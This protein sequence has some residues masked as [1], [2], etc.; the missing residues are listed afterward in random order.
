[1]T[2]EAISTYLKSQHPEDPRVL[3]KANFMATAAMKNAN[4]WTRQDDARTNAFWKAAYEIA[5]AEFPDLEMK[6]L[7]VTK[8]STWINFRPLDI[9]RDPG[10]SIFPSK[11]TAASWI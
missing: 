9:R 6:P 5:T 10:A 4:T 8:D 3:Y 1:V 11:G 7:T 2:Y